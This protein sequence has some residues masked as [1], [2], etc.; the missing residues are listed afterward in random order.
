MSGEGPS[1]PAD[2]GRAE[3]W[4]GRQQQFRMNTSGSPETSAVSLSR[5][6]DV[7][8]PY[9]PGRN[10]NAPRIEL[11]EIMTMPTEQKRQLAFQL[12]EAASMPIVD[13]SIDLTGGTAVDATRIP[14]YVSDTGI[15]GTGGVGTAEHGAG[16]AEHW[17]ATT[18]GKGKSGTADGH[19]GTNHAGSEVLGL[20]QSMNQC[21]ETEDLRVAASHTSVDVGVSSATEDRRSIGRVRAY[22]SQMQI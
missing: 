22:M 14:S 6:L 19:V 10:E 20:Q 15:S 7:Q 3:T 21:A 12:L 16:T 2:D 4:T 1:H 13:E 17:A 18:S 9:F 8:L 11:P 5:V